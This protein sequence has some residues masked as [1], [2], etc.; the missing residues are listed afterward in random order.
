MK[1]KIIFGILFLL[2]LVSNSYSDIIDGIAAIVNDEIIYIS[3]L[4]YALRPYKMKLDKAPISKEEKAKE[5]KKIKEKLLDNLINEKL[6]EEK[7]KEMH[8]TVSEKD[9]DALIQNILKEQHITLKQLKEALK[10]SHVSYKYYR[11]KLKAS[12]LRARVVNAFVKNEIQIPSKKIEQYVKEHLL[13]KN[14]KVTYHIK[15]IFFKKYDKQKIEKVLNLLKKEKFSEVAK[16]YSEGPF[17]NNGGDLGY[18]KKGQ[19]LPE[20]EKVVE[21]MK[22]GEVKL[23]KS[24]YGYH[25]I[26]LVDVKRKKIDKTALYN[27]AEDILKRKMLDKKLN[28]WIKELRKNAVIIKKI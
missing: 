16:K 26:K 8:Y 6:I 17:K 15:Q 25:I 12:I 11:E 23:V 24:K 14:Q 5:L 20:V 21:K 18:F 4:N 28:E 3:D 7:A 10:Q 19:M 2:L 1:K 27:K 13:P 22:V 9:V